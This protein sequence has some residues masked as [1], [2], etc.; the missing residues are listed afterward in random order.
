MGLFSSRTALP[1]SSFPFNPVNEKGQA[2]EADLNV[3]LR[4]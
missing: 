3:L 4:L 2:N 1:R